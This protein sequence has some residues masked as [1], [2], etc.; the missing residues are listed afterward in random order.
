MSKISFLLKG[1]RCLKRNYEQLVHGV[2][3]IFKL[4]DNHMMN[5]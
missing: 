4:V 5:G 3:A 2:K 1:D